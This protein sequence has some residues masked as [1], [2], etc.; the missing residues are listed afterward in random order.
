MIG[1]GLRPSIS[2]SLGEYDFLSLSFP[3]IL[4]AVTL[5]IRS[6]NYISIGHRCLYRVKPPASDKPKTAQGDVKMKKY[7]IARKIEAW[8]KKNE[9]HTDSR[10]YFNG[11]AWDYNS[12]GEKSIVEDV[13]A[14]DF[15][16]YGN[17]DTISMSFEGGMYRVMNYFW[18]RPNTNKLH[19]EFMDLIG[20]YGYY[21]ELGNAWNLSLYP[22]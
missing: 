22:Q 9:L 11:N 15:F 19:N 17:N 6:L 14:T 10:I 7:E 12:R 3:F 5:P 4:G 16:Q 13:K 21:F 8:M 20:G 2:L 18:E 1:G